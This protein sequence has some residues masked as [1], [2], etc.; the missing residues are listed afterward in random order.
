[1]QR[2]FET[3]QNSDFWR[4]GGSWPLTPEAISMPHASDGGASR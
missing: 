3:R 4:G 1:M 2:I